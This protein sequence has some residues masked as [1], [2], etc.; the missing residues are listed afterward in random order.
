MTQIKD[1]EAELVFCKRLKCQ[2]LEVDFTKAKPEVCLE[3]LKKLNESRTVLV[4]D[5]RGQEKLFSLEQ[6]GFQYVWNDMPELEGAAEPSHVETVIIPRTEALVR[7]LTGA[8][9]TVSF[10]HRV[11]C[12][13]V[14]EGLL[15]NNRA[16]AHSV[17]SDFTPAGALRNLESVIPDADEREQ[18]L[19]RRVMAINVWRPLKTVQR[20][21]LAVCDWTT[22]D[23]RNDR[24]ANRLV[25]PTGWN[26]LGK[27]AFNASQQWYYLAQQ[28]PQEA[29]IFTQF[30]SE[31]ADEGS[32]TL[33]HTAFVVPNSETLAA[34]ESIEI[35]MFAFF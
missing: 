28:Q 1:V 19:Q 8:T 5:L 22:L 21:P 2:N 18:L 9:R 35:K 29:L 26:E 10:T 23:W 25:L 3:S 17:H 11:R 33:P 6:N 16:P 30:D 24:I 7:Q 13:S 4:K 34:R 20:D 14:D 15:A 27:Y 12:F 32:M 31:Q